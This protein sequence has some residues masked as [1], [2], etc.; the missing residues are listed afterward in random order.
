MSK[1]LILLHGALSSKSQ[2]DGLVPLLHSEAKLALDFPGHGSCALER[3]EDFS[4]EGFARS[5]IST[6]DQQGIQQADVLGYSMG[7]YIAIYLCINYPERFNKIITLATKYHWS[8]EIATSETGK[9]NPQVLLEKA[10][11]FVEQLKEL[12]PATPWETLL[13]R[14]ASF[15]HQLGRN[16]YL[17]VLHLSNIPHQVLVS[18]GD[19]D[20]MVTLDETVKAFKA[21][22][23]GQLAVLPDTSHPLERMNLLRLAQLVNPFLAD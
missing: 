3:E 1:P 12:H 18:L 11:A 8:P 19:R 23:H 20:K 13:E 16:D 10:S 17:A 2:F 5:V 21:F 4:V 15:M 6:M 14:T 7:G 9:L 22:P